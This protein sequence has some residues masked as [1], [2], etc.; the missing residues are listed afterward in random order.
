LRAELRRLRSL[1]LIAMCKNEKGED[2]Q[3]GHIKDGAVIDLAKYVRLTDLG[4]KWV[5]RLKEFEKT[6]TSDEA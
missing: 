6:E 4:E 3:V 5:K 1:D 2:E